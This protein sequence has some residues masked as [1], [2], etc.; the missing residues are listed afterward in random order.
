VPDYYIV[1]TSCK[2]EPNGVMILTLLQERNSTSERQYEIT[3]G[4]MKTLNKLHNTNHEEVI[5]Q[6]ENNS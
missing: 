3:S 1:S 2:Q 6:L 5:N 4:T